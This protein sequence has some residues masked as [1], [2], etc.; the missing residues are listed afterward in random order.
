MEAV[1][2]ETEARCRDLA[3]ERDDLRELANKKRDEGT[4]T[5][6]EF[7]E[8][9]T[10]HPSC[11]G[12]HKEIINPLFGM[13]DFDQVGRY[14]T[15]MKGLGSTGQDGLAIDATGSLM[16]TESVKDGNTL[17]FT[18]AKGL[19]EAI[20][21]LEAVEACLIQNSFRYMLN[22]P[23][24]KDAVYKVNGDALEPTLT[25]EQQEDFACVNDQ[26]RQ[27]YQS[28]NE[29]PKAVKELLA[30]EAAGQREVKRVL[31]HHGGDHHPAQGIVGKHLGLST[32]A[33]A[34]RVYTDVYTETSAC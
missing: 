26:L 25:K 31:R 33:A 21:K 22:L 3:A 5:S 30:Q 13:E 24:N 1:A 2:Q 27:V 16:G 23:I 12:C 15:T 11:D 29:S 20:A 4:L 14:R 28:E 9:Q 6:R 8:I 18:G 34:I 17:N 19:G 7:F 32:V 10:N